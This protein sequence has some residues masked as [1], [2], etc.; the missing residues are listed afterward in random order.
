M[1]ASLFVIEQSLVDLEELRA[2]L[3]DE[4][5][6]EAVAAVDAQI[7]EWLTAEAS[8]VTSYVG[9]I[10]SKQ[11]TVEAAKAEKARV[12]AILKAAEADVER[13]KANALAVMQRFDV[14]ELKAVPGG[15]LRRQGNGGLEPLD[16][17]V[18]ENVPNKYTLRTVR[19]TWG[20]VETIRTLINERRQKPNDSHSM[21][22]LGDLE[23]TVEQGK[24]QPDTA[25]I[26]IALEQR[27]TCPE[28]KGTGERKYH[29]D[30]ESSD[31]LHCKGERKVPATVEGA[32]LLPKGEHVRVI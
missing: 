14:K 21:I 27:V 9:L 2:T 1:S 26:R 11:A 6:T 7:K 31:C 19:L 22:C 3:V 12:D 25:A 20:M 10:R 24:I 13:L 8:K 15:G 16:I 5:D 17:P 23:A 4:G 29:A 30:N 32:R 28:C 18:A